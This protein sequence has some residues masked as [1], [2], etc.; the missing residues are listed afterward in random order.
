[1]AGSEAARLADCYVAE[2]IMLWSLASGEGITHL[3][4]HHANVA[5]DV[6]RLATDFGTHVGSGPTAWTFMMHGSTEF[7]DI[8]RHDLKAKSESA[9]GVACISYYTRSQLM[10][11]SRSQ[12]WPA[13]DVIHCGVDPER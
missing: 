1:M 10:M 7:T 6:A 4:A 2:A 5:S 11:V 13:Y 9:A 8:Q 3:H 12:S